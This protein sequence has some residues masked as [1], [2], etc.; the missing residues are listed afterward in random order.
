MERAQRNYCPVARC[1]CHCPCVRPLVRHA[2]QLCQFNVMPFEPQPDACYRFDRDVCRDD[3]SLLVR[4]LQDRE[5]QAA[6]QLARSLHDH[7][8][9]AL[10]AVR[11]QLDMLKPVAGESA[12]APLMTGIGEID[13][14]LDHTIRGMRKMLAQL[15]PPDLIER[16]L[17]AAL[18]HEIDRQKAGAT[19]KVTLRTTSAIADARLPS[20]VA[21][22]AFMIARE[23]IANALRHARASEILVSLDGNQRE[24]DMAIIDDGIGMPVAPANRPAWAGIADM[25]ERARA[26][27]AAFS[28]T[29]RAPSG[30]GVRLHWNSSN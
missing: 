9:Q 26:L 24:F 18:E 12:P 3:L 6:Q 17:A 4:R 7:L 5:R 19:T 8:G 21:H 1:H 27:G 10:A 15:R 22:G 2:D 28:I 29:P 13:S 23:A 20:N 16:G 25:C 14:M 30:I 11:M